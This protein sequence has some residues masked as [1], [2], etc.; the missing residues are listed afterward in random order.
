ME[1]FQQVAALAYVEA[2]GSPL[3]LLVTTRGRGRWTIPKGWPK[4]KLADAET[5]A[6]EAFE[7]GGVAGEVSS[8]AMGSYV[9]TK[10]LHT[11]SW[12]RCRVTVYLLRV[13]RQ[14]MA[15]PEKARRTQL[16]IEPAKA[17]ELVKERQLAD[18]LHSFAQSAPRQD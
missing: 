1:P 6:R 5:A 8:E 11:F 3:V 10:R 9:Y 2:P 14:F 7:E 15:W 12:V 18:I 4:S 17:A 16:W 13:D